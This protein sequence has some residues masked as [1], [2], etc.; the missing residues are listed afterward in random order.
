MRSD[1]SAKKR[2]QSERRVRSRT[3][4]EHGN[5]LFFYASIAGRT[6]PDQT[7]PQTDLIEIDRVSN[8]E[9]LTCRVEHTFEFS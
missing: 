2:P 1:A 5:I 8:A 4:K 6:R 9:L 3:W 7:T